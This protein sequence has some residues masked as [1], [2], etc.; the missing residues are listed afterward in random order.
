MEHSRCMSLN[1]AHRFELLSIAYASIDAALARGELAPFDFACS[2]APLNQ[3]GASFV[4]LRI[5]ADL[6]GCCGSVE[7]SR[8]LSADVWNNAWASAFSDPRFP[9]LNGATRTFIFRC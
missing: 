3:P 4:T 6:R 5:G 9:P 1:P 8:L 7:A 2:D